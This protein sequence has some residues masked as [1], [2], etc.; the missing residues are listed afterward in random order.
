MENNKTF[1]DGFTFKRS[2][3]APDF[4]V[5]KLALKTDEAMKFINSH[6]KNGWLNLD[7]KKA[8]SGKFYIE[9]DNYIK[10]QA[11]TAKITKVKEYKSAEEFDRELP[12]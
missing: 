8:K 12:F 6:T 3:N 4:V 7:I 9:L 11:N 1:A 5:G 2:D 10:E